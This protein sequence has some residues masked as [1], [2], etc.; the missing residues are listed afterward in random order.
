M[1]R[2]TAMCCKNVFTKFSC[3]FNFR[4][5]MTILQSLQLLVN[6]HFWQFT[7]N[8]LIFQIIAVF[9]S[10]FS[11]EQL[12]CVVK[13]FLACFYAFSIFDLN[14]RFCKVYSPCLVAMFGNF[15]KNVIFW[16]RSLHRTTAMCCKNVFSM[17]VCIFNFWPIETI[18]QSV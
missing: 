8:A 2:T 17:F 11:I 5:K 10:R 4:P 15:E 1:H 12:Q 3:I 16:S 6:G 7:E 18:L 14:W 9:L 13:M